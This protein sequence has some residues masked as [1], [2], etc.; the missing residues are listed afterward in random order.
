MIRRSLRR[1]RKTRIEREE[2]EEVRK[3]ILEMFMKHKR[4]RF[5]EE[6]HSYFMCEKVHRIANINLKTINPKFIAFEFQRTVDV[7]GVEFASA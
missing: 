1:K 4:V 6:A 5:I 7:V 2:K 3:L